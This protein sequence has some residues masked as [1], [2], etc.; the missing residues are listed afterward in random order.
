MKSLRIQL[1]AGAALSLAA[2]A[3]A[4]GLFFFLGNELIDHTFYSERFADRMSD[5]QFARLQDYV[6]QEQITAKKLHRLNAW[7]SR[8]NGIDLTIYQNGTLLYASPLSGEPSPDPE[9]YDP[10]EENAEREYTLTFSDGST[11]QTFLYFYAGEGFYFWMIGVS[12]LLAFAVFSSCF[13]LLVNRKL[14]YIRQLKTELDILAGGKMEHAVTVRGQDELGELAAGIDEMRR[15][16]LS[17]QRDEAEIRAA[18]SQLVTAMSHDLRTPLTSLLAFLEL[19]DREKT[20][21]EAQRR[22]LTHQSLEKAMSIKGMADK[23]FEYFLVYTSEWEEPE[24]ELCDADELMQQFWQE[25]AF[26]LESHGFLVETRFDE[27]N[28]AVTVN[29]ELLRRAFDNLYANIVKY[30]DRAQPVQ[31]AYCRAGGQLRLKLSNAVSEQR[32]RKERTN[33]GL[34]TCRRILSMHNGAFVVN[35]SEY[36]FTVEL[37]LPLPEAGGTS[38]EAFAKPIKEEIP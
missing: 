37:R 17:H 29:P 14:R 19:L 33:I 12:G 5:R 16:I 28:G 8:G 1:L 18:N 10:E 22:R 23:L 7:C 13:I 31:I 35:Q 21:D 24:M 27:L 6:T 20:S 4:F 26:A 38:G 25:Y 32:D 11:A 30:A 2:A 15:S 36:L 3:L 34:N 9:A